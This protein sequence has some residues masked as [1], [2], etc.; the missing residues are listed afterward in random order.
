MTRLG[1]DALEVGC[2]STARADAIQRHLESR[3]HA[4]FAETDEGIAD[5]LYAPYVERQK[6]EWSG[7]DRGR[8]TPLPRGIDYRSLPG[9][10]AEMA[11]RLEAAR[12]EN[13]DQA[14]R[15]PGITPAALT[16]LYVGTLRSA[17]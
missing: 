4:A 13:L 6:R 15:V 2:L 12:P 11:E 10:S 17:A 8:M 7:V 3:S 14:S 16:A 9:L 1:E 5:A